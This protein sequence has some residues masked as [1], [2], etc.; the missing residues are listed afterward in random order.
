MSSLFSPKLLKGLILIIYICFYPVASDGSTPEG[1]AGRG[2]EDGWADCGSE[3]TASVIALTTPL[4]LA[5]CSTS[6]LIV[7]LD[8]R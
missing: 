7:T 4:P 1:E 6:R 2:S 3:A 5:L 8:I